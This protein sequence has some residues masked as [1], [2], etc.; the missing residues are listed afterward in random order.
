MVD[1]TIDESRPIR[2]IASEIDR[3]SVC[4]REV[5]L[6]LVNARDKAADMGDKELQY[7]ICIA[8]ESARE[9]LVLYIYEES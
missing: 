1:M 6:T 8:L 3:Q 9:K 2:I 4:M 5:V 7:L